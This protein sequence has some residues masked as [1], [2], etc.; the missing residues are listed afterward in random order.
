MVKK[1]QIRSGLDQNT[2]YQYLIHTES[3]VII[4]VCVLP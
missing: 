1:N 2:D 3:S 4:C